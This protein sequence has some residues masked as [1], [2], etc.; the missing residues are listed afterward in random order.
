MCGILCHMIVFFVNFVCLF[1]RDVQY[2]GLIFNGFLYACILVNYPGT[3][4]KS[5][6]AVVDLDQMAKG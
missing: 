5:L 4:K 1:H 6:F 3:Y 2:I